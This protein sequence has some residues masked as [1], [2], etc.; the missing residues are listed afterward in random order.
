VRIAALST[1]IAVLL[2]AS[3]CLQSSSRAAQGGP[4]LYSPSAI[5]VDMRTHIADRRALNREMERL[6]DVVKELNATRAIL[7]RHPLFSKVRREVVEWEAEALVDPLKKETLAAKALDIMSDD[8]KKVVD[9]MAEI[10]KQGWNL[11]IEVGDL[12][13]QNAQL[14]EAKR[15]LSYRLAAGLNTI[16]GSTE[17][18]EIT[19]LIQ[20]MDAEWKRR[21][22]LVCHDLQRGGPQSA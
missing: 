6:L 3:G 17:F 5:A 18:Q 19:A 14:F 11:V 12:D 15:S 4:S 20:Q 9:K 13:K 16:A 22:T 8:E 1:Y 2:T 10:E 21:E 7:K